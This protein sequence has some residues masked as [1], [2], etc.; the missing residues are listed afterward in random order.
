[1][2]TLSKIPEVCSNENEKFLC[3]RMGEDFENIFCCHN[4]V[5]FLKNINWQLSNSYRSGKVD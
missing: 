1:M 4:Q 2:A 3:P 5:N